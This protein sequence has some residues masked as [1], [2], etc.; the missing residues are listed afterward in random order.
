MDTKDA[1]LVSTAKV[2][3]KILLRRAA[4]TSES[5]YQ[6]HIKNPTAKGGGLLS[7]C[8]NQPFQILPFEFLKLILINVET[9]PP[10]TSSAILFDFKVLDLF[11]LVP[12][13]PKS[14]LYLF[15]IAGPRSYPWIRESVLTPTLAGIDLVMVS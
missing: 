11:S 14:P 6:L 4:P 5:Q 15:G 10:T 7:Y 12:E 2:R 3:D 8:E 1:I 13:G 9:E